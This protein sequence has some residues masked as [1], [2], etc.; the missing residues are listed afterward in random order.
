MMRLD[1]QDDTGTRIGGQTP[2]TRETRLTDALI[3]SLLESCLSYLP[4]VDGDAGLSPRPVSESQS[5]FPLTLLSL[6]FFLR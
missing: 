1:G 2:E 3:C 4:D 5:A 6:L